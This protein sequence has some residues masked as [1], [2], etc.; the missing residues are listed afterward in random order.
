MSTRGWLRAWLMLIT[1]GP[2]L[3]EPSRHLSTWPFTGGKGSLSAA[4][5]CP[6][7]QALYIILLLTH[8]LELFLWLHLSVMWPQR[9]SYYKPRRQ[10]VGTIW[11]AALMTTTVVFHMFEG[12]RI[13]SCR[14]F[15]D[16]P[17]VSTSCCVTCLLLPS[18]FSSPFSEHDGTFSLSMLVSRVESTFPGPV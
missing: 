10:R 13:S 17:L 7:L 5:K 11:R 4:L 2:R 12:A 16:S 14:F 18:S 9:G 1:Q 15:S 6:S 3:S 8:C